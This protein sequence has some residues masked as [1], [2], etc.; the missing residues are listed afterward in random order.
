MSWKKIGGID[1][2]SIQQLI[3]APA[4]TSAGTVNFNNVFANDITA[5]DTLTIGNVTLSN[6]VALDR[7]N[8]Y[9]NFKQYG[10][11]VQ[12]VYKDSLPDNLLTNINS[13]TLTETVLTSFKRNA[14]QHSSNDILSINPH[15]ADVTMNGTAYKSYYTGGVKMYG[16]VIDPSNNDINPIELIGNTTLNGK[17]IDISGNSTSTPHDN[18]ITV[19]GKKI[20]IIGYGLNESNERD[21]NIL[22]QSKDI[23]IQNDTTTNNFIDISSN[24]IN[25]NGNNINFI[26]NSGNSAQNPTI[27]FTGAVKMQ[28]NLHV[29]GT[30]TGTTNI[31]ASQNYEASAVYYSRKNDNAINTLK[32]GVKNGSNET[33]AATATPYLT[34][35]ETSAFYKTLYLRNTRGDFDTNTYKHSGIEKEYN[36]GDGIG[37]LLIWNGNGSGNVDSD[38]HIRSN[39]IHFSTI[40]TAISD[41]TGTTDTK[42]LIHSNGNVGVGTGTTTPDKLLSIGYN[43]SGF[44]TG[45]YSYANQ[46]P[47]SNALIFSSNGLT[48]FTA[49]IGGYFI[50]DK[51]IGTDITYN[52]VAVPSTINETNSGLGTPNANSNRIHM[53]F[54]TSGGIQ[55]LDPTK[56]TYNV[57]SRN[58]PTGARIFGTS[59]YSS[60]GGIRMELVKPSAS[61]IPSNDITRYAGVGTTA[62]DLTQQN[63]NI[64]LALGNGSQ[65]VKINIPAQTTTNGNGADLHINA[66]AKDGLGTDGSV[67]V[68]TDL[69]VSDNLTVTGTTTLNNNVSV[70]AG[71]TLTVGTGATVLGGTLTVA[72]NLSIYDATDEG[73]PVLSLGSSSTNALS[74]TAAYNTGT[75]KLDKIT[76]KTAVDGAGTNNGEMIFNIGG[77]DRFTI[78]DGGIAV[79]ATTLT[80]AQLTNIK[81]NAA[82]DGTTIA[83][84]AVTFAKIQDASANTVIVRN[85]DD[86]GDLSAKVLEDAQILIGNGNGFNTAVL[87]GDVTMTNDGDVTIAAG[88]VT[89][90]KMAGLDSAKIILGNASGNPSARL[91]SGDVTMTN[92]GA[93]TIADN[94]VAT[95]KIADNAVATAKIADNAVTLDKINISGTTPGTTDVQDDHGILMKQGTATTLTTVQ[96]LAA[97]LDD[98][99]TAMPYLVSVGQLAG[100]SITSNFGTISTTNTITST[101]AVTGGSLVSTGATTVGTDLTVTGADI[102]LGNGSDGTLATQATA[103][104]TPGKPMTI[105][106]GSTTFGSDNIAGGGLTIKAGQGTGTGSGG[107]IVFK[108]APAGT[109]GSADSVNEP[110]DALIISQ[111]KTAQFMAAV[112]GITPTEDAHLATKG[113]V[114]DADRFDVKGYVVMATTADLTGY[115][116]YNGTAGVGATLT[117]TGNGAVTIDGIATATIGQRVL[118]KNQT[119]QSQ[120][121]IYYVS[122]A[123]G[124]SAALKLTRATDFDTNTKIKGSFCFVE[125]GTTNASSGFVCTNAGAVTLGTTSITFSKFSGNGFINAGTGLTKSGN[126]LSVSAA[127]PQIT[128]IGTSLANNSTLTVGNTEND[129]MTFSPNSTVASDVITIK[130]TNGTGAS[131]IALTSTAGGITL[132]PKSDKVVTVAGN[133]TLSA[134]KKITI[135]NSDIISDASGTTTLSNIDSI[136]DTTKT[137]IEN[138]IETLTDLTIIG[139]PGVTTQIAAGDLTMYNAVDGG[140]PSIS[141]GSS[142]AEKLSI[143]ATY[144]NSGQTL[145]KVTFSTAAASN[146]ENKGKMVFNVD[147]TVILD[148]DDAG[149]N[150]KSGKVLKHNGTALTNSS[151]KILGTAVQLDDDNKGL[152]AEEN[153]LY[154][155]LEA[156]KGLVAGA[157]GLSID[158]DASNIAGNGKLSMS[159]LATLD[160]SK[161]LV[162]DTSGVIGAS[163]VTTTD[164]ATKKGSSVV[165]ATTAPL[166]G[167]SYDEGTAG[168]GATLTRN[169]N[170][171]VTIDGVATDTIGQRV[172]V[173][174]QNDDKQNGIYYVSAASGASA[175]LKLTRATDFDTNTKIK[176]SFCF[177]E[178]GTTNASSGFVCTNSETTVVTIGET[179]ITFSKFTVPTLSNS[180]VPVTNASGVISSSSVTATQLAT[181]SGVNPG[182][183]TAGKALVLDNNNDIAGL[184]TVGC[185]AITSSGNLAITGTITGDTSLTLDSTT[186]TTAEIGVLA[187]V[188]PGTATGSKALVLN[189][190]SDIISGL[191]NLTVGGNLTINGT[192]TSVNSTTITIDDPIFTLGGDSATVETVETSK[193]RGI[194]ARYGGVRFSTP[195]YAVSSSTCTITG[196]AFNAVVGDTVTIASSGVTNLDGT[197]KVKTAP[198]VNSFTITTVNVDNQTATT[199]TGTVIISKNAFFGL[200]QSA[201]V[202]TYLSRS[203]N[204]SEQ[205]TG[206]VGDVVFGAGTFSGGI[207]SGKL[208]ATGEAIELSND[209]SY[210]AHKISGGA[211]TESGSGTH[212]LIT[213]L[214]VSKPTITGAGATTTDAATLYI[215][216]AP[217]G[218][219]NNYALLVA[220][221]ASKF[222][223]TVDVNSLKINGTAVTATAAELN[224]IS[225][226]KTQKYVYAAPNSSDGAASFRAL[227]ASDIP[228]LNQHTTGSAATVTTAAQPIITTLVALT[229]VGDTGVTTTFSGPISVGEGVSKTAVTSDVATYAG[230]VTSNTSGISHTLTL[231]DALGAQVTHTDVTVTSNKVLATSVVLSSSN[232]NVDVRIH[233]VVAGSFKVSITNKS[234]NDTTLLNGSTIILNYVIL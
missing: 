22:I 178:S 189:S 216:N 227:V 13:T 172:L 131:A 113:Y 42:M 168:V 210:D 150:L 17:F 204:N 195:T 28:G 163:D 54:A 155:K 94:A 29:A 194:E 182:T 191:R 48:T 44:S 53:G 219:T 180:I 86:D 37:D 38:I 187:G 174:N 62:F 110:V 36:S 33:Y 107:N 175:A 78:N 25:I 234:D 18:K 88:A 81:R 185:G 122:T 117:G 10:D 80:A 146:D 30:L 186:I 169:S 57:T 197:Y 23:K 106:S 82:S 4:F 40:A 70:A 140:N 137:T 130:N 144:D 203:N 207:T 91:L 114:D 121:G 34:V 73:N 217:T 52:G 221:G 166:T 148:I 46:L 147:G 208:T 156:N 105:S 211:I 112:S 193:D 228:T 198:D 224:T 41:K 102:T 65:P 222:A 76:F 164:L 223:G 63:G 209:T 68:G 21:D 84:N 170:G 177:V 141:L 9:G 97:Y 50:A 47:I 67:I 176:G 145:D 120:N 96:T 181:I 139:K 126:T 218:A 124:A 152:V 1:R 133:M 101:A 212:P 26:T 109:S 6:N 125:S 215:D 61:N 43:N 85:A 142:S 93:V 2:S 3:Q 60:G 20:E 55:L 143:T 213:G 171:D 200:D 201:G 162:S 173:K 202:F 69:T 135:G 71:K 27:K 95:A 19:K 14:L 100:G 8:I 16:G 165:M 104:G 153:G 123:S 158:L 161:V 77:A 190:N 11:T 226:P 32:V 92:A 206:T 118:V 116:Y 119:T 220:A 89:F 196:H 90:A 214:H 56:T 192:T 83:N 51:G 66:G 58:A 132:T 188:T 49:D 184:G 225:G 74:I 231:A 205:M 233:T 111:N 45:S 24:T 99:I 15:S 59:G 127:Q 136:D 179:S 154:I 199:G 115:N 230:A 7:L 75:Q 134:S 159:S 167:Y 72:D 229:A 138:A 5:I 98:E 151:G 157:S 64:Q 108:V 183:A 31:E 87:S 103:A 149:I 128:S 160:V 35:D 12:I 129:S 232:L 39:N 79:G